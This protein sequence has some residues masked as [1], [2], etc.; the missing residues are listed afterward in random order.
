[1]KPPTAPRIQA[2]APKLRSITDAVTVGEMVLEGIEAGSFYIL[3]DLLWAQD[4]ISE[5]AR[6][7]GD[8]ALLE[9]REGCA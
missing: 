2:A 9:R 8:L 3:T 7:R 4:I 6:F 1:V 5:H